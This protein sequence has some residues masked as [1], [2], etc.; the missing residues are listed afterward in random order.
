VPILGSAC[1]DAQAVY[2]YLRFLWGVYRDRLIG[3]LWQSPA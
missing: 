2:T 3:W 1:R